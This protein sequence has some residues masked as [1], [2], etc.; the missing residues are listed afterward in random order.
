MAKKQRSDTTDK[1]REERAKLSAS[2]LS[3]IGVGVIVIGVARPVLDPRFA[4][5]RV[6]SQDASFDLLV[7][8]ISMAV[9]VVCHLVARSLLQGM[10][11]RRRSQKRGSEPRATEEGA[12]R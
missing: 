10:A 8:A 11:R 7:I 3:S 5:E 12:M 9:G 1:V 6:S 2:F 4:K